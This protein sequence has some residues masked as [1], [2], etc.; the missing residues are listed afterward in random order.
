MKHFNYQNVNTVCLACT[1]TFQNIR[2]LKKKK[3]SAWGGIKKEW[4]ENSKICTT[5]L[6]KE[7]IDV[8]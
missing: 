5:L 1:E 4:I 2:Y 6:R 8:T 7:E 3:N